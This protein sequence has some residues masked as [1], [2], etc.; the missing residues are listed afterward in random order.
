MMF[1][2]ILR[3]KTLKQVSKN[4]ILYAAKICI[5]CLQIFSLTFI[6]HCYH[7]I[8]LIIF[9]AITSLKITKIK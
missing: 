8:I 6:T 2:H 5:G 9:L 7:F 4:I 3:L 1:S